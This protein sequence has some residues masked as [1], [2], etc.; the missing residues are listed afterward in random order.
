LIGLL[1]AVPAALA[2]YQLSLGLAKIG[3][4]DEGWRE[5]FALIGAVL[6]GITAFS[7][8]ALLAPPPAWRGLEASA[9]SSLN[10]QQ[11]GQMKM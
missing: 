1:Y 11:R 2:G 5:A 10:S 7:R 9:H 3:M 8:M 6:V 4:T